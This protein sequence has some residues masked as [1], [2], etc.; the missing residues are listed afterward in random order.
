MALK[1]STINK[2]IPFLSIVFV[3]G[4]LTI[5]VGF[6]KKNNQGCNLT[7]LDI[8]SFK[9]DIEDLNIKLMSTEAD[10][11]Q[12]SGD[13]NIKT[14]ELN[15]KGSIEHVNMIKESLNQKIQNCSL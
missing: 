7:A 15:H 2:L 5:V 1:K 11:K 3:I 10:L 8:Q 13:L 4:L 9:D 6:D 14:V 12:D